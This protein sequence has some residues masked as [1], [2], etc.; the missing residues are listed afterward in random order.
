[1]TKALDQIQIPVQVEIFSQNW[2]L[3]ILG[4]NGPPE[5]RRKSTVRFGPDEDEDDEEEDQVEI[6]G[7]TQEEINTMLERRQERRRSSIYHGEGSILFAASKVIYAS[8]YKYYHILGTIT[9]PAKST[10]Q[11][12]AAEN[13]TEVKRKFVSENF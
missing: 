13:Q 6:V 5:K 12:N 9:I 11:S 7:P 4:G 1:M 2:I 8:C 10:Q 3:S